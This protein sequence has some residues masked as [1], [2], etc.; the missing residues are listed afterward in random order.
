MKRN[1][2]ATALLAGVSVVAVTWP[3]LPSE[4]A[5][6]VRR[7]VRWTDQLAQADDPKPAAPAPG[8]PADGELRAVVVAA[9]G[10][11][12]YRM[13]DDA[14]WVPVKTGDVLPAGA[15]IRTSLSAVQLRIEPGHT[16]TIDRFTVVKLITL[17]R[18]DGVV[19]TDVGMKYGRTRYDVEA[20]GAVHDAKIHTPVTTLAI[21]GTE[22]GTQSDAFT[23]SSW[24]IKGAVDNTNKLRREVIRMDASTGKAMVTSHLVTPAEYKKNVSQNDP[25]GEFV[26]RDKSPTAP[27]Q[28][29]GSGEFDD[30]DM[31]IYESQRLARLGGFQFDP[32]G[33]FNGNF[34]IDISWS[35]DF[36]ASDVDLLIQDPLGALLDV[37][38]NTI[39]RPGQSTQGT[40]T[41]IPI[42]NDGSLG[43]GS[44]SALFGPRIPLGNYLVTVK[45]ISGDNSTGFIDGRLS[46]V[47]FGSEA[48]SVGGDNPQ[49]QFLVN[50]K[51]QTI[52]PIGD[53][54]GGGGTPQK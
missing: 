32:N 37:K 15:E 8:T 38:G 31:G 9:K 40:F 24:V 45:H 53:L 5:T 16:V 6:L 14:K 18:Q 48:F 36:V 33:S 50:P 23:E 19:K 41:S 52:I 11:V 49:A 28:G 1:P 29:Y 42:D 30:R 13:G 26:G 54:G 44:E 17:V 21:R 3:A 25:K 46:G 7:G 34:G 2:V 22:S 4:A 27:Q 47:L 51:D 20:A 43:F 10:N 12:Q 39:V 35:P